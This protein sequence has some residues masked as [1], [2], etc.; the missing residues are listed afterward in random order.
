[1]SFDVTHSSTAAVAVDGVQPEEAG[2]SAPALA[3][4]A[5][6]VLVSSLATKDEPDGAI[7]STARD[8]EDLPAVALASATSADAPSDESA[9][10]VAEAPPA[11]SNRGAAR[12]ANRLLLVG[13]P[14]VIVGVAAAAI[15]ANKRGSES[16]STGVVQPQVDSG[17]RPGTVSLSG[18]PTAVSVGDTFN[19]V[20]TIVDS[21][22][23]PVPTT[24]ANWRSSN[25][26]IASVDSLSGIV[27]GVGPG[28][29][30]VSADVA[31]QQATAH[32]VV[33]PRQSGPIARVVVTPRRLRLVEGRKQQLAANLLDS[34]NAP[35]VGAVTW[36]I[37]DSTVA[38]VDP[39]TGN[40]TAL[41]AGRTNVVAT[42]G[43][44]TAKVPLTVAAKEGESDVAAIRGQLEQF[45]AALN[46]RNA[47][48]VQAIYTAESAQDKQNLDFLLET[49][50]RAGS[51][52]RAAQLTVSAPEVG[53]TEATANFTVRAS[54]KP[55]SGAVKNQAVTFRATLER[56]G[57]SWKLLGVRA[58]DKLE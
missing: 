17:P 1:V 35:V 52:F 39:A 5:G 36:Q 22:R 11:A 24:A 55:A 42:S 3:A 16:E 18:V 26:E 27:T 51:N 20:A 40:V 23:T 32:L 49:F 54:W 44:V 30:T 34:A 48:R 19:L 47:Q 58:L 37:E 38:S 4:A 12:R 15:I 53:W 10:A 45:V 29:A 41:K 57:N 13:L 21:T 25:P 7:D 33:A 6:P 9:V 56:A 8:G 43:T 46:A 31:G 28:E 2:V 50:K 14:L